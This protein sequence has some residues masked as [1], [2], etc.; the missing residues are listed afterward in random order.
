MLSVFYP[1]SLEITVWWLGCPGCSTGD[2]AVSW[3]SSKLLAKSRVGGLL[4]TFDKQLSFL[5][6]QQRAYCISKTTNMWYLDYTPGYG[7]LSR[8][9]S[10]LSCGL[11][12]KNAHTAIQYSYQKTW[13]FSSRQT[14]LSSCNTT[15]HTKIHITAINSGLKQT[16]Y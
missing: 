7:E 15:P 16:F 12:L 8:L 9:V 11:W 13:Q 3:H 14:S 5:Q 4:C 6:P 1:V 2:R 10:E